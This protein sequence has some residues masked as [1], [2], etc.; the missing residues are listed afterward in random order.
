MRKGGHRRRERKKKTFVRTS[1]PR[2]RHAVCARLRILINSEIAR[3]PSTYN[4]IPLFTSG[5]LCFI[6]DVIYRDIAAP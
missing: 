6:A 5:L 2:P 3:R 4:S 1:I